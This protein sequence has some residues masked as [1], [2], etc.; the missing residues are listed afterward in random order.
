MDAAE[1][2]RRGYTRETTIKRDAAGRWSQNG[3]ALEHRGLT[4]SFDG[5]I[6]RAPD[7]RF[8]LHNDINWAYVAIDGPPYFV[9]S[10]APEGG[11]L[12]LRL[13]GDQQEPLDLMSLRIDELDAIWCDVRNGRVPARFDN[14]AAVQL[15]EFMVERG[16]AVAISFA[17]TEV[18]PA[19]VSDPMG[20]WT[21]E[22]GHVEAK[23]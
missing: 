8:C 19:R 17:G 5:W 4:R 20:G 23:S 11:V 16:D 12:M 9:R 10:L 13:S 18:V 14:H 15:G 6:D 1:M 2:L 21:V 3:H 22:R 7:G